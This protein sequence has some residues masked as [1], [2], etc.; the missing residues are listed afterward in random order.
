MQME[1]D[2]PGTGNLDLGNERRRR[3]FGEEQLR[4]FA[5]IAFHRARQLH[6]QIAGEI[7]MRSLLWPFQNDCGFNLIGGDTVQ[8]GAHQVSEMNFDVVSHCGTNP[9]IEARG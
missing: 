7:A 6:G 3:N 5:G 2:E 8:C 9:G 1:I 4:Q